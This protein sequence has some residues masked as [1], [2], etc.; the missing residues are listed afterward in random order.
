MLPQLP[1]EISLELGRDPGSDLAASSDC[2]L[3]DD[4]VVVMSVVTFHDL[5]PVVVGVWE[6]IPTNR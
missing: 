3:E 6:T 1:H 5:A 4:F 2:E